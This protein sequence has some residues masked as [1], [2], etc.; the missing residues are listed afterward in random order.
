[1]LG[2]VVGGAVGVVRLDRH[3]GETIRVSSPRSIE[4]STTVGAPVETAPPTTE[5]STPPTATPTVPPPIDS[6][7][8]AIQRLT[9]LLPQL[10]RWGCSHNQYASADDP[11][12]YCRVDLGK[13][14]GTAQ[15]YVISHT[16][17][18][19]A[20]FEARER[21]PC[22]VKVELA[23]WTAPST[24]AN[25]ISRI[26]TENSRVIFLAWTFR[27][28]DRFYTAIVLPTPPPPEAA[29]WEWWQRNAISSDQLLPTG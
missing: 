6:D 16:N 25:G 23:P 5:M 12:F 19:Q 13:S 28:D 17:E 24:G 20:E 22:G 11:V 10:A 1:V 9:Q 4:T 18:A 15:M 3:D 21:Y 7:G 14:M 2:L 27:L 26:C 8:A 29:L